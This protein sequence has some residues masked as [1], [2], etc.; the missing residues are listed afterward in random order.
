MLRV[1]TVGDTILSGDN[2]LELV[3][4]HFEAQS[5]LAGPLPVGAL[6]SS[7]PSWVDKKVQRS[8]QRRRKRRRLRRMGT[9]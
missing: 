4:K 5:S 2:A 9:F 1:M 8:T 6:L 7:M 3:A